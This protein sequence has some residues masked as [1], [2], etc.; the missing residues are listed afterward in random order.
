MHAARLVWLVLVTCLAASTAAAQSASEQPI[1]WGHAS[2]PWDAAGTGYSI[3]VVVEG[4]TCA[5]ANGTITVRRPD[6]LPIWSQSVPVKASVMFQNLEAPRDLDRVLALILSITVKERETLDTVLPEWPEGAPGP[7]DSFRAADGV[8]REQWN[9]WRAAKSPVLRFVWG[10]ETVSVYVLD[11]D[12]RIRDVG[13][14]T[15][16]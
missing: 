6:G 14:Y 12:G 4:P 13:Y 8:R 15:P 7:L 5:G 9:T 16:G 2:A 11:G 1:C 3:T 10:I